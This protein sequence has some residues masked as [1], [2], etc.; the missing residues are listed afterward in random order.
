MSVTSELQMLLWSKKLFPR[1]GQVNQKVILCKSS[2]VVSVTETSSGTCVQTY[3]QHK[4]V[5][6]PL[7]GS[8]VCHQKQCLPLSSAA[9]CSTSTEWRADSPESALFT[10]VPCQGFLLQYLTRL[11]AQSVPGVVGA[12]CAGGCEPAR[13]AERTHTAFAVSNS[14][15][16][17]RW[18]TGVLFKCISWRQR[19]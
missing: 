14:R 6:L 4:I 12:G 18:V 10:G 1:L 16:P 5:T 17:R 15:F 11:L 9:R 7:F 2:Y 19:L 3:S 13:Y 8:V